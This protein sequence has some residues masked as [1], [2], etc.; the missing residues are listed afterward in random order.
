MFQKELAMRIIARP[1]GK[2]YGRLAVML[3]YCA[4]IKKLADVKA[5]QF[6]PKPKVDSQILEIKFLET[7]KH[8]AKD[9][10]FFFK[11]VKAAF[12]QRRKTLRNALAG[13]ELHI[14]TSTAQR[15]LESTG[16][17][18]SRRAETLTV[19]AFVDLSNALEM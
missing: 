16:I 10:A 1:G 8:P 13:S 14:D 12:G 11:V 3:G 19:S 5:H 15:V 2:D 4:K 7:V 6:F 18:P 9:E 17:E